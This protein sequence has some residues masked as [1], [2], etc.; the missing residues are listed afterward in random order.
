MREWLARIVDWVRRD[1]LD[2]ELA[3]ELRFHRQQ[4]ERDARHDGTEEAD[5]R[6]VAARRLGNV[7][8]VR[9][10][11]RERW[12]VPV[13]DRLQHDVRYAARGLR[14]SPGF[15]A[16]VVLVLALGIG[17]N[18]AMF[19][20]VDRLMFRPLAHMRDPDTVH[21]IYWRWTDGG[22]VRTT[23]A[24]FFARYLALR[25]GTT[26]FDVVAAFT[27]R[28]LAVGEGEAALERRVAAVSASYFG[29]FDARP[30]LGRFFVEAEDVAPRGADVA[31]LSHDFW[32][33]AYGGRDVLGERLQIGD[34]RAT[35]VGVAPP[36]FAGVNDA[37]PPVAYLPITAFAG[38][39]ASDDART[40]HTHYRWSW[41]QVLVRRRAGVGRE[42]AEAD[43]TLAF[44]RSWLAAAEQS[45]RLAPVDVAQPRAIVA[46]V[47]A[48]AGPEPGLA[49]R[50]A[51]WLWAVAGLVLL[52]AVANVANLA[53]AR[54]LRRRHETAVR[55]AL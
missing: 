19:D 5:A 39:S 44:R 48:G 4:L 30:A 8:R 35:I 21:R 24:T 20:V 47:R 26:S 9:E 10:D 3:E 45:P 34:V 38:S 51:R 52:I 49:S 7:T 13:L 31:V 40:Y 37:D 32:R 55:I 50:T 41:A 18:A 1:A 12:S 29:L 42:A 46:P 11:A 6:W 28:P 36:G 15:T 22:T 33:T 54:A 27:E 25:H 43:A 23:P 17:A 16:T 53:L 14:R 2:R